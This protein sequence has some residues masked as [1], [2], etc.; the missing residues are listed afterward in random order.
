MMCGIFTNRLAGVGPLEWNAMGDPHA[1]VIVYQSPVLIHRSIG[2]DVTCQLQ[3][4]A[5]EVRQH[6]QKGLLRRVLTFAEVRFRHATTLTFHDPLAA[7]T[8][9]HDQVC[10]FNCGSVEVELVSERTKGMN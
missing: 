4:P 5:D 6:F 7:V 8:F 2:L 3:M 1:S 10:G 9:F